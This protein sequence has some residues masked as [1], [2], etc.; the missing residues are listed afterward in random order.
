[1]SRGFSRKILKQIELLAIDNDIL[2]SKMVPQVVLQTYSKLKNPENIHEARLILLKATRELDRFHYILHSALN[3]IKSV[4]VDTSGFDICLVALSRY[5]FSRHFIDV[6]RSIELNRGIIAVPPAMYIPLQIVLGIMSCIF[7]S[8]FPL[9][10]VKHVDT[11]A[12]S[13]KTAL[14]LD[15]IDLRNDEYIIPVDKAT[16]DE[17]EIMDYFAS[18][19]PNEKILTKES[20]ADPSH[21]IVVQ[22]ETTSNETHGVKFTL[23]ESNILHK[24]II[25]PS[26]SDEEIEIDDY[27]DEESE[28]DETDTDDSSDND[29]LEFSDDGTGV[30][31][32]IQNQQKLCDEI[33]DNVPMANYTETNNEDN[34]QGDSEKNNLPN[35]NHFTN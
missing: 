35:V 23:P 28:D 10:V 12:F 20:K 24:D 11:D 4:G 31:S 29:E 18:S 30:D 26:Y 9:P 6:L 32:Q 16:N 34:K 7:E 5:D 22:K 14:D 33:V 3:V 13:T 8:S 2:K 25:N 17:D 27:D 19:F 15:S 1:M 21:T